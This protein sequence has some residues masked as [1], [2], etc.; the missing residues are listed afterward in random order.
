MFAKCYRIKNAIFFF[1][2]TRVTVGEGG[3]AKME[4]VHTFLCFFLN[5]SLSMWFKTSIHYKET[6]HVTTPDTNTIRKKLDLYLVN[7]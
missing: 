1:Y 6:A 5:P 3:E 7:H 4:S 2:L